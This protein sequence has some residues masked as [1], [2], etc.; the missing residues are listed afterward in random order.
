MT[1]CDLRVIM[2]IIGS[3]IGTVLGMLIAFWYNSRGER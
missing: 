3:L 1:A 2:H